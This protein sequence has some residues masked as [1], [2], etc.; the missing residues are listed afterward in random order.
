MIG[1]AM[2]VEGGNQLKPEFFY[3]CAVAEV[4]LK[5]RVDDHGLPALRIAEQV[6]IGR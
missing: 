2:C 4:L 5:H 3:Q 1:M 6:S